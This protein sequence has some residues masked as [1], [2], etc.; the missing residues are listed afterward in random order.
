MA[1]I[2][3]L[4]LLGL[5]VAS[6][7]VVI[8]AQAQNQDG[9]A[10]IPPSVARG[11]GLQIKSVADLNFCLQV[12]A[13]TADG[14]AITVQQCGTADNQ[15][16]TFSMNKDGSNIIVESAGLCV[17][18]R[19]DS[20]PMVLDVESCKFG[21]AFRFSVLATGQIKDLKKGQCVTIAGAAA[22]A[23]VTLANC[24]ADDKKQQFKVTR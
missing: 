20:N 21:D 12:A 4:A 18:G 22:N 15:R 6:G 14:R 10:P 7:F 24:N 8:D 5:V 2:A 16:F 17:D 1:G 9:G 11:A 13:G 3:R 19:R 23:S